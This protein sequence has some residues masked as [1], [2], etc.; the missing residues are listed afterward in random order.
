MK[1]EEEGHQNERDIRRRAQKKGGGGGGEAKQK[2]Y[3]DNSKA[4]QDSQ[5]EIA[6]T[7]SHRKEENKKRIN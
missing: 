1:D 6:A 7:L 4:K 2:Q 5:Y 3:G